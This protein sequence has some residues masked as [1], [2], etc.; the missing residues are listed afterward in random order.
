MKFDRRMYVY[1]DING[2]LLIYTDGPTIWNK[3]QV[4]IPNE[5]DLGG[6]F[7]S[8]QSGVIVPK[9]RSNNLVS[10]LSSSLY[11]N[12]VTSFSVYAYTTYSQVG[13][14]LIYF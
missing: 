7:S 11:G 13:T 6:H 2:Q 8:S 14:F 4:I 3:N 10:V 9:P 12:S 5:T 1:S